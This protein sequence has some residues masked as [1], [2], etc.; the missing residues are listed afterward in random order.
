[1]IELHKKHGK[2]VQTGPDEISVPDLSAIKKI[3]GAG[4]KF[5]K[6][7]WYSVWQGHRKFDLFAERDENIHSAQRRL[8]SR[9][10]SMEAL[11]DLEKYVDDAVAHFMTIM[12]TRQ[13]QDTN[14]AFLSN[15]LRLVSCRP[16]LLSHFKLT[17]TRCNWRGTE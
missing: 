1:M 14:M 13:N 2:L 16:H 11:N 8:V 7:P 12:Q 5:A 4:T 9:I 15:Y 17:P 6:S 10:Y 3:Y